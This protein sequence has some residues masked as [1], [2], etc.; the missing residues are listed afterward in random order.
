MMKSSGKNIADLTNE[1]LVAEVK[2]T[3][4]QIRLL[5]Q[6]KLRLKYNYD[7]EKDQEYRKMIEDRHCKTLI[8]M[9]EKS[10]EKDIQ[11]LGA[12][13]KSVSQPDHY[14]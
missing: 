3:K 10:K 8:Q 1:E 5:N 14:Y 6:E 13:L 4:R 9:A 2:K 11:I 12:R 7:L